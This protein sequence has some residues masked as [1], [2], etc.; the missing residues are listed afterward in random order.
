LGVSIQDLTPD[1]AG[2]LGLK[3]TKGALIADAVK[4]AP[5]HKAGLRRGDVVIAYMGKE[6]LDSA[7][8]RNAVAVTPVGERAVVTVLRKGAKKEFSVRVGDLETDNRLA[9]ASLRDRLGVEVRAVNAG[10]VKK[11]RIPSNQGAVVV[12]VDPNGPLGEA[13]FEP[14]DII[15][16]INGQSVNDVKAFAEFVASLKPNER[17]VLLG[18]DHGSGRTGYVQIVV[19]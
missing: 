19:N 6:I 11:Y 12:R 1:L 9:P 4:D 10:D 8:L 3:T 5:A 7:G 16:E 15:L 18:L 17:I 2:S 14:G 13:G